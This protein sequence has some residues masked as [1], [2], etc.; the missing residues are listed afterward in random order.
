MLSRL[1]FLISFVLLIFS[2]LTY[3]QNNTK[4]QLELKRIELLKEIKNTQSLINKSKDNKKLIFENIENLNYKLDLQNQVIRLNNNELNIL[5]NSIEQNKIKIDLLIRSQ[6]ALKKQYAE[7]ILRSF[8]TRSKTQKLMFIF[9]S[10]NF[11][12]ALK[13]IQY[14]KQ[15]SD[16][17]NNQLLK[18]K[19]N[20]LEL[21]QLEKSL[22][23]QK[24]LQ[25]NLISKNTKIKNS[26]NLEIDNKNSLLKIIS[27]NQIKYTNEI[28]KKQKR[29]TEIDRQIEKIIA[30]AIAESNKKKSLVFE[31]T[32][33]AKALSNSFILNK[34][35]LPWPV[36]Q[37]RVILKYGRQPHPIVKT[38]TIQSNGIRIMTSPAQ[39]VR[40][41]FNGSVYR[42]ISSKNGSKT[43]LIQHGNFFTVYKNLSNIYV[44]KG[45]KVS[46]MQE[47]GNIITNKN[48]GQTILSFSLFKESKTQNPLYWLGQK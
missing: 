3:G 4:K 38:A 18:I 17:Q 13:R 29:T 10:G 32:P 15:Y 44:K 35:K 34:G 46:T 6:E 16:H 36:S 11:Q 39:K 25:L 2:L 7:M 42:I 24:Q 48:S 31:L 33:E 26:I 19:S 30:D 43:I 28:K 5:S 20:T 8:K 37:G 21:K 22:L 23:S 14:F 47:L 40:S 12:Q 9:S 27:N 1:S 41:I 45:E